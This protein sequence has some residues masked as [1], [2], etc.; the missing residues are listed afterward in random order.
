M[1]VEVL[2]DQITSLELNVDETNKIIDLKLMI[3]NKLEI[4]VENQCLTLCGNKMNDNLTLKD[5]HIK[6]ESV[7]H[8]FSLD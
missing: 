3:R 8:L 2:S 6:E 5:Y 1:K 7:I 4:P